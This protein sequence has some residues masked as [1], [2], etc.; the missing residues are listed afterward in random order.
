[1]AM[2]GF[3]CYVTR[4]Y[5]VLN[6]NHF[7]MNLDVQKVSAI[8]A[9]FQTYLLTP[10]SSSQYLGDE[11]QGR[12]LLNVFDP[13]Y[14]IENHL[15]KRTATG[16]GKVY[17][18]DLSGIEVVLRHYY[19]GGLIAKFIKDKF[20]FAGIQNTRAYR[21]LAILAHLHAKGVNVPKPIVGK[22]RVLGLTYQCD[23]LTQVI[24]NAT[25][26]HQH[27]CEHGV[28]DE[29]WKQIGKEIQKLHQAQACH[30]DLNVKNLLVKDNNEIVLL[31]FDNC[32]IRQGDAWKAKNLERFKRSLFKQASKHPSYGFSEDKWHILTEAY[33]EL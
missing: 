10:E 28:E 11:L 14:L 8:G 1:M 29:T 21:E 27:L 5:K 26:L 23:I 15:V 13:Q 6:S 30:Y 31:D 24:D 17:F 7:L 32:E 4:I 20:V 18:F 25:E 33:N 22:V 3:V 9:K 12:D 16:R 2:V 19:R